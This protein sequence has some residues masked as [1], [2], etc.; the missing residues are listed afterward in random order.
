MAGRRDDL[1]KHRAQGDVDVDIMGYEREL[2][3]SERREAARLQRQVCRERDDGEGMLPLFAG[4]VGV[5]GVGYGRGSLTCGGTT[6]LSSPPPAG[7]TQL[8]CKD[9]TAEISAGADNDRENLRSHPGRKFARSLP[10]RASGEGKTAGTG[11]KTVFH[12]TRVHQRS[13]GELH[14]PPLAVHCLLIPR[15]SHDD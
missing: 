3:D 4:D 6:L 8:D 15:P 2:R 5:G 1:R 10:R 9:L 11:Y 14:H 13:L 12:W 7:D